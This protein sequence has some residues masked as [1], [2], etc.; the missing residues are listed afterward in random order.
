MVTEGTAEGDPISVRRSPGAALLR[1]APVSLFLAVELKYPSAG[2][3]E[4]CCCPSV[5]GSGPLQNDGSA[6]FRR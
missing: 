4:R 3:H 5:E 6:A 1:I 2:Q